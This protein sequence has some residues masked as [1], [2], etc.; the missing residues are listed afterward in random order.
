MEVVSISWQIKNIDLT[1]L[2]NIKIL[3]FWPFRHLRELEWADAPY[4]NVLTI[5]SPKDAIS[6]VKE[7]CEHVAE[8]FRSHWSRLTFGV[9]P[10]PMCRGKK[11]KIL[12]KGFFNICRISDIQTT[13]ETME[14]LIDYTYFNRH[15]YINESNYAKYSEYFSVRIIQNS[16][17]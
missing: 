2:T 17:F 10:N 7:S 14:Y 5:S 12:K 9:C 16:Y 15:N 8:G 13:K 4:Q 1:H 11:C 3:M 6:Q